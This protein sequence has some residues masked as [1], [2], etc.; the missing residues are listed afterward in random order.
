MHVVVF[1][2]N[3]FSVAQCEGETTGAENMPHQQRQPTA[4]HRILCHVKMA[5]GTLCCIRSLGFDALEHI[6][7]DIQLKLTI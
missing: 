7:Y 3:V 6:K 5:A 1:G 2:N 4:A